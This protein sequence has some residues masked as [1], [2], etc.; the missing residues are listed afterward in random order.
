MPERQSKK[1]FTFF[2]KN[3]K[4]KDESGKDI[5]YRIYDLHFIAFISGWLHVCEK[6]IS[7]YWNIISVHLLSL[8]QMCRIGQ[9]N[10]CILQLLQLVW[11]SGAFWIRNLFF[12]YYFKFIFIFSKSISSSIRMAVSYRK[13]QSHINFMLSTL[14]TKMPLTEEP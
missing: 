2:Q 6:G 10:Y 11:F 4:G 3:S 14:I 8:N 9:Q 13:K 12:F 5:E 1:G 7:S